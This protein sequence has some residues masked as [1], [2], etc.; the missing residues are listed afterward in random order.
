MAVREQGFAVRVKWQST[1]INHGAAAVLGAA[2]LYAVRA[3]YL[4]LRR[5]IGLGLGDVKLAAAGGAWL[6]LEEL[7]LACLLAAMAGLV[8]IVGLDRISG[9]KRLTR[10]SAVPF[11]AF[12]APAFL[13]MWAGKLIWNSELLRSF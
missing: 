7:P 12:M 6:G 9:E 1:L 8:V 13:I 2:S 4:K 5:V 11:A 10:S 3:I